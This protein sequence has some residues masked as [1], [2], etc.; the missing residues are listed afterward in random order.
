MCW[1]RDVQLMWSRWNDAQFFRFHSFAVQM[2]ITSKKKL[3]LEKLYCVHTTVT[4][5]WSIYL[6]FL[7]AQ[8]KKLS[9]NS[10]NKEYKGVQWK[11]L[12]LLWGG[13]KIYR[14]KGSHGGCAR[15]SGK[16]NVQWRWNICTWGRSGYGKWSVRLYGRGMNLS[17]CDWILY[18]GWVGGIC[19]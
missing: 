6:P 4:F 13:K 12:H 15:P 17:I 7:T 16:G 14:C 5:S 18:I 3:A 10:T 9:H 1:N 8:N 11:A 19:A 2:T